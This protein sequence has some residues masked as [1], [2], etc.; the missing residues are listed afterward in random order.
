M[1]WN[2]SSKEHLA[3]TSPHLWFKHIAQLS[4]SLYKT[5]L[6]QC[7][8]SVLIQSIAMDKAWAARSSL[9]HHHLEAKNTPLLFLL[10]TAQLA[11]PN[12]GFPALHQ[13]VA[14]CLGSGINLQRYNHLPEPWPAPPAS[15]SFPRAPKSSWYGLASL[16]TLYSSKTSGAWN[17]HHGPPTLASLTP[18]TRKQA[19]LS[20]F[21]GPVAIS[22]APFGLPCSLSSPTRP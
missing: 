12:Q 13:S 21:P 7:R 8:E 9:L 4:L 10:P 18:S 2:Q 19:S 16:P 20:A 5:L 6:A 15:C 14:P 17:L 3:K 1:L 22:I 11:P